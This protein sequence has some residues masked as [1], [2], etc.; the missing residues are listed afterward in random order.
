M[1][2]YRI[3]FGN[4]HLWYNDPHDIAAIIETYVLNVYRIQKIKKNSIVVDIGAGIGE[5]TVLASSKV[6]KGGKIIAIEPSPEDFETLQKNI[7][8]NKCDNVIPINGAITNKK[9]KLSL[10][11]KEKNFE[12]EADTLHSIIQKLNVPLSSIHYIKMDIEGA[13]RLVIPSSIDIIRNIDY[14]AI[15][16]HDGFASELL[17]YMINHGFMFKRVERNEYILNTIKRAVLQPIDVYRLWKIFKNTGENPGLRKIS[18]G[19]DI[20]KSNEL[21]VGMFFKP[22]KTI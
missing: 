2:D 14:I 17:P 5:F 8:E 9:E 19:I 4:F 21:V 6:G 11:F 13:E 22:N 15:E 1:S 16:I 20:S 7:M 18:S 10:T 12:A 3:K